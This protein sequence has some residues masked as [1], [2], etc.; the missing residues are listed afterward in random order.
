MDP[1]EDDILGIRQPS[2]TMNHINPI[3]HRIPNMEYTD[4]PS[5]VES[6][7]S[8][9]ASLTTDDSKNNVHV[10]FH[11]NI[12]V[13]RLIRTVPQRKPLQWKLNRVKN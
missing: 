8:S 6:E 9:V 10:H 12:S 13:P 11:V 3:V 7:V 2:A 1:S 5:V 4:A